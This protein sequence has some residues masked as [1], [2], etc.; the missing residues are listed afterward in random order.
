MGG[1]EWLYLA[2]FAVSAYS[3]ANQY[4]QAE[5]D[6]ALQRQQASKQAALN[7]KLAYNA[8]LNLNEQQMFEMKKFGFDDRDLKKSIRAKQATNE[9]IRASFGGAFGQSGASLNATI[10]NINRHGYEAL[11]RKDLNFKIQAADFNVRHRNI[12][13][14][15]E[16]K[17][18]Q[19]FSGLSTGGSI[20][21]TGLNILGTGLQSGINYNRGTERTTARI[22]EE[23]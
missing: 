18:N 10:L 11:A 20:L 4:Q 21:G 5:Q 14:E 12:T 8:H 6:A 16:S 13:L 7:N 17:N 22:P 23:K 15:T 9:A 19:A 1:T 2:Q 3:A